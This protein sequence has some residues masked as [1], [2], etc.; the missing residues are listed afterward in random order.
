M[1]AR[2]CGCLAKHLIYKYA[3]PATF[4]N[5]NAPVTAQMSYQSGALHRTLNRYRNRFSRDATLA[6]VHVAING[7]I[8]FK[9]KLDG[10]FQAFFGFFL[11]QLLHISAWNFVHPADV[12]FA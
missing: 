9:D 12:P 7:L 3:M 10:L 8:C 5:K 4:S 6:S 1:M 2:N 11:G